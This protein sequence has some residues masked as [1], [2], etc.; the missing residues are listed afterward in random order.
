VPETYVLNELD[1]VL[2]CCVAGDEVVNVC[3]D[4][5]ADVARQLVPEQ[6]R[7]RYLPL[8]TNNIST[9]TRRFYSIIVWGLEFDKSG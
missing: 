7:V 5:H 1:D 8:V 2:L 3:H 4:V 9:L 6:H